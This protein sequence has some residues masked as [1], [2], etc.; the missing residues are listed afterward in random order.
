VRYRLAELDQ[1]NAGVPSFFFSDLGTLETGAGTGDI[2]LRRTL[3]V[4]GV[5]FIE[6]DQ[7]LP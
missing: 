3:P 5:H 7:P 4:P 2:H 1:S 6:I